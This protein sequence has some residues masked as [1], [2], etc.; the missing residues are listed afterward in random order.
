MAAV[1]N[2]ST[3]LTSLTFDYLAE[4]DDQKRI[5]F[6]HS[7]PGLVQT[8]IAR[9]VGPSNDRNGWWHSVLASALQTVM[10]WVIRFFGAP[11]EVAGQKNAY[12]LTSESFGAGSCRVDKNCEIVSD[13]GV[14]RGYLER[15]WAEKA[16]EHTQSTWE[17]ALVGRSDI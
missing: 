2:H 13:N 7:T 4:N 5:T 1:V 10:G 11:V 9:A 14:L 8:D 15:G 17:N 3:L 16:W 12:L 6:I